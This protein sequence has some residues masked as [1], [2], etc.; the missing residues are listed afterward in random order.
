MSLSSNNTQSESDD[1]DSSLNDNESDNDSK[2][3]SKQS[4]I[5]QKITMMG[6]DTRT[7]AWAFSFIHFFLANMVFVLIICGL[8][9]AEIGP[10]AFIGWFF[11]VGIT[12]P[13]QGFIAK[14]VHRASKLY[15]MESDVRVKFIGELIR[16][17]GV[18]KMYCWESAV[19]S[20]ICLTLYLDT[21]FW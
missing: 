4:S 17:I 20:F 12:G 18:T 19:C 14:L 9:F 10:S 6:S 3:K 8:L 2:P 21:Q 1:S 7:I 15:I 11:F 16:G 5:G 13:I